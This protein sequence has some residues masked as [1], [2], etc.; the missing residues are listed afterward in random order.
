MTMHTRCTHCDAVFRVTLRQLQSSSGQVRCGVCREAF[1]AF[2]H[3][4]AAETT[5]V[6]AVSSTAAPPIER[7]SSIEGSVAAEPFADPADVVGISPAADSPVEPRFAD[8]VIDAAESG[9]ASPL[10]SIPDTFESIDIELVV[11]HPATVSGPPSTTSPEPLSPVEPDIVQIP[12]S[13]PVPPM[14][15]PARAT[16]RRPRRWPLALGV[17]LFVLILAVQVAYRFRTWITTAVPALRPVAEQLCDLAGCRVPLPEL[18]DRLVIEASDL[19]ALDPTR[20]NRVVLIATLRNTASIA[21]AHPFVEL[22]FTDSREQVTARKVFAPQDYLDAPGEVS[23][24]I[25][26]HGEVA[27]RMQL[28][29]G[30]LEVAGYRLYLFHR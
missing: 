16:V 4:R 13:E 30:D 3:L 9:I 23:A 24:G 12:E 21:Q 5:E 19:R 10:D 26:P 20:P 18:S 6:E 2:V 11:D 27:I 7:T 22:S 25:G 1:D 29:V 17:T 28:D 8:A 15:T 14:S